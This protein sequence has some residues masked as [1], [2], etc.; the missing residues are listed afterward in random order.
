MN[1]VDVDDQVDFVDELGNVSYPPEALRMALEGPAGAGHVA[2]TLLEEQPSM[3]SVELP[4]GDVVDVG[5][6][7]HTL[8][9]SDPSRSDTLP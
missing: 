5:A 9:C 6:A 7:T 8:T 4:A 1:A 2:Q 3:K